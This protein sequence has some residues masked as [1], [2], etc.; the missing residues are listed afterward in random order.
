MVF[1]CMGVS[2]NI[3]NQSFLAGHLGYF[4]SLA[5][6]NKATVD[7]PFNDFAYVVM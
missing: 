5:I 1:H 4:Q 3:L 7:S 6:M 2:Q